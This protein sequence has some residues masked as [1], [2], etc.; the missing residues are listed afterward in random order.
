MVSKEMGGCNAM[1]EKTIYISEDAHHRLKLLAAQRGRTMGE[2]VEELVSQEL[3]ELVNPWTGP[4]GLWL[5]QKALT[6]VWN[7]SAL[8]VYNDA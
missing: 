6:D 3:A 4:E 1:R 8:D 7:D 5:Q 2:I